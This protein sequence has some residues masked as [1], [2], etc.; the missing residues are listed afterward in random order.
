MN[1]N[2]FGTSQGY[3]AG[4]ENLWFDEEYKVGNHWSDFEGR[5][6]YSIDGSAESVDKYPLNEMLERATYYPLLLISLSLILI[7]IIT[8]RRKILK[9]I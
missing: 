1:N 5:G 9:N 7:S 6:K 3:D 8:T 2:P 4:R